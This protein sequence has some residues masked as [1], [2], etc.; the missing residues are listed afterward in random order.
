MKITASMYDYETTVEN[1]RAVGGMHEYWGHG[2]KGF[3]N[4][5]N[6]HHKAYE[7][8][9][10]SRYWNGTSDQFKQSTKDALRRYYISEKVPRF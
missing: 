3:G 5:N 8:T 4:P 6:N 10:N 7:A 2:K 9:I 1:V